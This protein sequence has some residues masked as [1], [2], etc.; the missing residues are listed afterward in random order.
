M[1]RTSVGALSAQ[2]EG[3]LMARMLEPLAKG[4]GDI[5]EGVVQACSVSLAARDGSGF[6]AALSAL[7]EKNERAER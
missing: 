3:M 5:G 4:L 2:F 6:A 1:D 7:L